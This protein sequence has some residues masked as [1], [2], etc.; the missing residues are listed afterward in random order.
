[1]GMAASA[2]GMV[3]GEVKSGSLTDAQRAQALKGLEPA[4]EEVLGGF[5]EEVSKRL[6]ALYGGVMDEA[7]RGQKAWRADRQAALA[8]VGT[9]GPAWQDLVTRSEQ[10]GVQVG[11]MLGSRV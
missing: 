8:R 5:A 6:H 1:V 7:V 2:G 4:I 10:L 3:L 11:S 9:N